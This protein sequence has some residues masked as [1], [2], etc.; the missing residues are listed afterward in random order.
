[1]RYEKFVN[2]AKDFQVIDG[3]ALT[4]IGQNSGR[5]L[6]NLMTLWV[7][8]GRMIRLRRG[9]YM[10]PEGVS[11]QALTAESAACLIY[12][13]SY[14]SLESALSRHELIPERVEEW[15]S[16]TTRKTAR[17]SNPLGRFSY[18]HVAPSRFFGFDRVARQDAN[19]CLA[20]PEKALLDWVYLDNRRVSKPQ[21]YI[22]ILRLQ[23]TET[24]SRKRFIETARRFSS[25]K[26]WRFAEALS[27]ALR[28]GK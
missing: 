14:I 15:T 11:R 1:M 28:L 3:A 13:P 10:L 2:L 6:A 24:L 17:F 5:T 20:W 16:L 25:K 4:A 8:K 12:F 21:D 23:N 7:G 26:V 18:A 22:E 27:K 9:L 19:F